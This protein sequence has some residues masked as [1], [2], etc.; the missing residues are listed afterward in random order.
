M[1]S[2]T[3]QGIQRYKFFFSVILLAFFTRCLSVNAADCGRGF[4]AHYHRYHV[5][6]DQSTQRTGH[7]NMNPSMRACVSAFCVCSCDSRVAESTEEVTKLRPVRLVKEDGIIRPYDPTESQGFDLFLVSPFDFFC[8]VSGRKLC[9]THACV[10]QG[11]S[12][13]KMR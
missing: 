7:P 4:Y 2:S 9:P 5:M 6:R 1:A 11:R 13:F 3:F 8:H 12:S 10:I